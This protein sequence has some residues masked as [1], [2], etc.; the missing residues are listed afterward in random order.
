MKH[1]KLC[2][3][4]L[5]LASLGGC[6][7]DPTPAPEAPA[8]TAPAEGSDESLDLPPIEDPSDYKEF[9]AT[10]LNEWM[11][12]RDSALQAFVEADTECNAE[13]AAH[14][15]AARTAFQAEDSETYADWLEANEKSDFLRRGEIE[16]TVPAAK[17][18]AERV[19][20]DLPC[21][22]RVSLAQERYD[23]A[24]FAGRSRY[25]RRV[26][27]AQE[28]YRRLHEREHPSQALLQ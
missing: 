19:P 1:F 17:R 4:A 24:F 18:Y 21:N 16:E 13:W 2:I 15:E 5:A 9:R 25:K 23:T 28:I 26:Q 27:A 7:E 8:E 6:G 11:E 14:E 10:A 12:E 20:E 22:V 3:A